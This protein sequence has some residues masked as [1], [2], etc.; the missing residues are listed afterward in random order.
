MNMIIVLIILNQNNFLTF[1]LHNH[2]KFRYI[3]CMSILQKLVW[4]TVIEKHHRISQYTA[5][6]PMVLLPLK[7]L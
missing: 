5:S 7:H 3:L 2:F 4:N 6:M 1:F